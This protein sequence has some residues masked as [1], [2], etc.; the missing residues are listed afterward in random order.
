MDELRVVV[1]NDWFVAND[2]VLPLESWGFKYFAPVH[3][4]HVVSD[5]EL[6]MQV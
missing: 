6:E 1:S 2:V 4:V 3:G 5:F